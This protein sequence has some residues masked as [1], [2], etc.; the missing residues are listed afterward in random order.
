M[1]FSVPTSSACF[2]FCHFPLLYLFSVVVICHYAAHFHVSLDTFS[3]VFLSFFLFPFLPFFHV[4][5][6]FSFFR[7]H[8]IP[9]LFLSCFIMESTLS[10]ADFLHRHST[11]L[12]HRFSF[13]LPLLSLLL[14]NHLYHT[15]P[16]ICKHLFL[17]LFPTSFSSLLCLGYCLPHPPFYLSCSFAS[18]LRSSQSQKSEN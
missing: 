7:F 5:A 18:L 13:F 3:L 17:S 15:C 14:A 8:A 4:V 6:W 16:G 10:P 9:L 12:L 11:P 1:I 2:P